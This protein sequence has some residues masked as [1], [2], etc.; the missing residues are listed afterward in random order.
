M[1]VLEVGVCVVVMLWLLLFVVVGDSICF[2]SVRLGGYVLLV[3]L[4]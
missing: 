3:G 4:I 1:G 2:S